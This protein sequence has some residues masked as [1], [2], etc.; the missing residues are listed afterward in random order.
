MRYNITLA[1]GVPEFIAFDVEGASEAEAVAMAERRLRKKRPSL[2]P[3]DV[4]VAKIVEVGSSPGRRRT[5][6]ITASGPP[7]NR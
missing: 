3:F 1:T 7:A 5:R 6:R 2:R 4:G